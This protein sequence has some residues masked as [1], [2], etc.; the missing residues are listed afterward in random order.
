[1]KKLFVLTLAFMLIGLLSKAQCD[2]VTKWTCTKMKIV[3]ASGNT[4]QAKDE[5]VIVVVGNKN[6]EV[7]PQDQE[8]QMT[9][10]VS[11]YTCQWP[12]PGKNG[13]TVVKGDV[14][15]ASGKL[16]H[17]T[18][19]IEGIKGNITITLEAPEETTKI[20]LEVKSYEAVK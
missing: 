15:D 6:I 17:A 9:G 12:E 11:D 13:K 7:T 19:T 18:I 1:M 10:A 8:D 16:R 4:V 14:T 5:N 2:G 3:D 20:V